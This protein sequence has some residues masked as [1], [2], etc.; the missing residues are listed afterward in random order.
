VSVRV[1]SWIVAPVK[2]AQKTRSCELLSQRGFQPQP[3]GNNPPNYTKRHQD[4]VEFV[5]VRGSLSSVKS[6]LKKQEAA[7]CEIFS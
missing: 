1:G 5:W 6:L 7:Y 3:K 2:I 4:R